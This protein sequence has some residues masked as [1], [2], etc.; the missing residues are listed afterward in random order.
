MYAQATVVLPASVL[1]K[2]KHNM[3][4]IVANADQLRVKSTGILIYRGTAREGSAGTYGKNLLSRND[5]VQ[6]SQK[7]TWYDTL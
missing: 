2:R 5:H 4:R 6:K 7:Y 3:T 1:Y